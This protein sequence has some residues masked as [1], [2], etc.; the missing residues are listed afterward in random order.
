MR[1]G[2]LAFPA[3]RLKMIAACMAASPTMC[4][5]S[6]R[7]TKFAT[8][9]GRPLCCET[10]ASPS[11]RFAS[12]ASLVHGFVRRSGDLLLSELVHSPMK[13]HRNQHARDSADDHCPAQTHLHSATHNARHLANPLV[14]VT[15]V[16]RAERGEADRAR[17][18]TRPPLLRP[19]DLGALSGEHERVRPG[20]EIARPPGPL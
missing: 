9:A 13:R 1:S 6:V 4:R 18:R 12:D 2:R 8:G 3:L 19:G 7:T 16:P 10:T 20:H 15:V 5:V 14:R 11:P 17:G